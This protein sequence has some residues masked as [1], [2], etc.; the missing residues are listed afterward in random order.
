MG[1][2]NLRDGKEFDW[3]GL[4]RHEFGIRPLLPFNFAF[5]YVLVK[6]FLQNRKRAEAR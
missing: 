4:K 6:N 1:A 2:Q 5:F 3:I